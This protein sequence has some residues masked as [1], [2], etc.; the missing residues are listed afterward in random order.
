MIF[1]H[2]KRIIF[3][4]QPIGRLEYFIRWIT[5][6]LLFLGGMWF[7]PY[8][9]LAVGFWFVTQFSLG[10]VWAF[11]RLRDAWEERRT[12]VLWTA[13]TLV[14]PLLHYWWLFKPNHER[15][16]ILKSLAITLAAFCAYLAFTQFIPVIFGSP[17]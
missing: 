14:L 12:A 10:V 13:G 16:E 9:D 15:G 3:A 7:T 5:S 17:Q 8:R 11:W 2:L 6:L 1:T 4:G